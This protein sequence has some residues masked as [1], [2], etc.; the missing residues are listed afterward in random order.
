MI[1]DDLGPFEH[2]LDVGGNIG[3]FAELCRLTWPDA[4]IDSFEPIPGAANTNRKRADRSG[5]WRVHE[6]AIGS[7]DGTATL[8]LCTN[9]HSASTMMEPGKLRRERFGIRDVFHPIEVEVARLDRFRGLIDDG[10]RTLL[11]V[12]VEGFELEVLR[13]A[14]HVL[15]LVHVAIVEINQEPDI[16]VGAPSPDVVDAELRNVGLYFAGVA[17]VQLDPRGEVVQFDGVW[18]R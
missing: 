9:Q 12:D 5:G 4:S 16:F 10:G 8:R 6:V 15:E 14:L 7:T 18:S 13:G 11:K 17:G 2:V 1:V 3:E